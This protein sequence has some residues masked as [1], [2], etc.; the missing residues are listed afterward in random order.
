MPGLYN[1]ADFRTGGIETDGT[2]LV[3]DDLGNDSHYTIAVVDQTGAVVRD[4]DKRFQRLSVEDLKGD[5]VRVFRGVNDNPVLKPGEE[6][7]VSVGSH[8]VTIVS[9]SEN[10]VTLN[11]KAST[12]LDEQ[13]EDQRYP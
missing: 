9:T 1:G 2:K 11:G 10:G 3:S 7:E 13:I 6:L 12:V 8:E 4:A 5:G